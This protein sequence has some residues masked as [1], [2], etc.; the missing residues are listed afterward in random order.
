MPRDGI[1]IAV[2]L[3][4]IRPIRNVISHVADITTEKCRSVVRKEMQGSRAD[5]VLCDGAPNVGASYDKDSYEQNEIVLLSLRCA[6]EHLI[7]GGTFC[8]KVYRSADY[9]SLMWVLNQLFKS[10]NAV[11][12]AASRQ[13]SAEIFLVCEGYLAPT[14][15][16]PKL[17]DPK[18]VFEQN[19]DDVIKKNPTIFD[20][21]F[22]PKKNKHRTGYDDDIDA[23]MRRIKPASDFVAA[24]DPITMLSE[25][26]GF[27]FLQDDD[28]PLLEHSATNAA[29]KESMAD[30]KLLGKSEFKALLKWRLA[31]IDFL[32]VQNGDDDDEEGEKKPKEKYVKTEE[33]E[34]EDIQGEIDEMRNKKLRKLKREKKKEREV[35]AKLR[36]RKRLG[37]DGKGVEP[38]TYE[39]VFSLNQIKSKKELDSAGAGNVR[40]DDDEDGSDSDNSVDERMDEEDDSEDDDDV[41][42]KKHLMRLEAQM[43]TQYDTYLRANKKAQAGTK[44]AKRSKKEAAKKLAEQ[45][46][47]D[48]EALALADVDGETAAYAKMLT[49]A[50]DSDDSNGESSSDDGFFSDENDDD[51]DS[52][53][54]KPKAA[55]AEKLKGKAAKSNPLI[56]KKEEEARSVK[57]SRFLSN[58][59][60]EGLDEDEN[61][62]DDEN[63]NA[64]AVNSDDD[65]DSSDD[66]DQPRKKTKGLKADDILAMMPKTDKEL[67]HEKRARANDRLNRRD[68][69]REKLAGEN[70]EIVESEQP[71]NKADAELALLDDKSKKRILKARELIKAGLGGGVDDDK[72]T[73]EIAPALQ[74]FDD[75]KYDSEEE[76]YDSDDH[77]ELLALGTMMLRKSKSKAIVDAS[78]N[79]FASNDPMDLPDWFKDDEKRHYRPQL[80]I[81]AALVAKMKEKYMSLS[82]KPIKKVVEARARKSKRA[83]TALKAA[84]AKAAAVANS[85]DMSEAQKLKAISKALRGK[86]SAAPSKQ[87]VVAKNGKGRGG[88]GIK[89]VDKRMK[90]DKRAEKRAASKKKGSKR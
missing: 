81:P 38:E 41:K 66:E 75:R 6:T 22:N 37:M 55:A 73:L 5:V 83:S 88:K 60:F 64:A 51:A 53:D 10:V 31:M 56:V 57:V 85:A 90:N 76:D 30:L 70:L 24:E 50:Q 89:L 29:I 26:H 45:A 49:G 18:A 4:P 47:E 23:T 43:D 15:I 82:A 32:K 35:A 25:C 11:K 84:K 59:L 65:G 16:D 40:S 7:K 77:A 27:S 48:T 44:L 69:R 1:V 86:E 39:D 54:E 17:L 72:S 33:E 8:T 62:A 87:Y 19:Y 74:K 63:G 14:T 21:D 12:P 78:Y 71:D 2:D 42:E 52:D 34:E 61:S 13:Q 9:T 20:K 36:E 68:K 67:R 58:P 79:R 3:L 80:P 28:K 46:Q